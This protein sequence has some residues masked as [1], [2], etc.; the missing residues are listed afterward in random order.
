[1]TKITINIDTEGDNGP[2]VT[3]TTK[4]QKSEVPKEETPVEGDK[5]AAIRE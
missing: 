5:Q 1:M 4:N 3:T 2:K